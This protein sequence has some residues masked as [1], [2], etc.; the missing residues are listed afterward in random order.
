MW[1]SFVLAALPEGDDISQLTR[2][3]SLPLFFNCV[4]PAYVVP[5]S[6]HAVLVT[7][8]APGRGRWFAPTNLRVPG[9]GTST[10][11]FVTLAGHETRLVRLWLGL[12]LY[13]PDPI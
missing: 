6:A 8:W 3:H 12:V 13:H 7:S 1:G 10:D 5:H 9:M 11:A 2:K 4:I